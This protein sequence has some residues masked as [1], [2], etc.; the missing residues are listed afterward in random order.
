MEVLVLFTTLQNI[1][2]SSVI[3]IVHARVKSINV[4]CPYNGT[5][6]LC[7]SAIF[8]KPGFVDIVTLYLR[9]QHYRLSCHTSRQVSIEYTYDIVL[10]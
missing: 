2:I 5:N 6:D 4:V 3:V 8:L 1:V 10:F 7:I 9:Q